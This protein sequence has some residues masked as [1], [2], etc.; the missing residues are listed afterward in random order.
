MGKKVKPLPKSEILSV[1]IDPQLRMAAELAAGRER[2]PLSSLIEWV[3]ERAM[4]DY[5]VATEQGQ[6]VSAWRVAELCWHPDPIWRLQLLAQRF[7]DFMTFEEKT[8][9]QAVAF[10]IGLEQNLEPKTPVAGHFVHVDWLPA[11]MAVWPYIVANTNNLDFVEMRRLYLE[12]R[13]S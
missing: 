2:R 12:A 5:E 11:L 3:L 9:W 8:R 4:R 1:R 10:L 6:P 13:Q 7:P